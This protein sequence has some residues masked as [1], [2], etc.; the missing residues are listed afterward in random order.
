MQTVEDSERLRAHMESVNQ[1]GLPWFRGPREIDPEAFGRELE[2]NLQE[3]MCTVAVGEV[4]GAVVAVGFIERRGDA[5]ADVQV[6]VGAGHRGRGYGRAVLEFLIEW[7]RG[8]AGLERLY[9]KVA[10]SNVAS[11]RMC[12]EFGFVADVDRGLRIEEIAGK[13]V[14]VLQL[15]RDVR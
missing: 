6:S 5:H 12:R 15:Y 14:P 9:A 4:S 10:E 1:E 2:V 7:A 3:P 8:E 11:V 13:R